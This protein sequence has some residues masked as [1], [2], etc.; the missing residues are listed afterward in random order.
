VHDGPLTVAQTTGKRLPLDNAN[1]RKADLAAIHIAKAALHLDDDEYRD[2]MATVCAG[3]RSSALLDF[4][5]RK[6]FLSHLQAC[7]RQQA[8]QASVAGQKARQ[9]PIRAPLTPTQRKIWALWMQLADA[10]L[11]G[12]R[13]MTALVAY[14]RR[15]TGVERLEWLNGKQ[16]DLVIESMKRWLARGEAT[17]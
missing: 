8:G 3:V 2:L 11:V 12:S 4:A 13:T 9:R 7:Q 17:A 1:G 15:Q 6:R 10:G 14:C 5:G 16:Q